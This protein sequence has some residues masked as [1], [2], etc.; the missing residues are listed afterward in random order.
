MLLA[1]AFGLAI[2]L[3]V[4]R[5][6]FTSVPLVEPRS[7]RTQP[8]GSRLNSACRRLTFVSASTTSLLDMRVVTIRPGPFRTD[9]VGSIEAK[10]TRAAESSR[11][12]GPVLQ[13]L[14]GRLA[15]EQAEADGLHV[16]GAA[17]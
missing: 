4:A 12:F 11:H 3:S 7:N 9:M 6:P 14:R 16:S 15:A 17:A 10:F 5:C 2:G 8:S 13:R 1:V